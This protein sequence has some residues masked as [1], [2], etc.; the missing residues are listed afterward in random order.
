MTLKELQKEAV[1]AVLSAATNGSSDFLTQMVEL[2][3]AMAYASGE[4][5]EIERQ[6]T[7]ML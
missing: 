3:I 2:Q 4:K 1:N 7:K 5:A 6:L